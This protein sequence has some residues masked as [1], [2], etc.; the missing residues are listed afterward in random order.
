MNVIR[1]GRLLP[2]GVLVDEGQHRPMKGMALLPTE[3]QGHE[4]KIVFA[5]EITSRSVSVEI[6][7]AVLGRLLSLPIPEPVLL[8]DEHNKIFFGSV[9][10]D[11]PS[12]T[13]Y[14][15]NSSDQGVSNALAAWP[16]LNKA[17]YFDELIAMD[18]RHNGN[19]LY[20]GEDFILID[21]ESA[22]PSG[23]SP[24]MHGIEHYSNQLLQVATH[25]LDKNN[26]IAVQMMANEARSWSVTCKNESMPMLDSEIENVVTGKE[27][28]HLLSF[29]S[30]RIDLLGDILYEQIKPQQTQMIYDAKS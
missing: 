10:A 19:L 9:D 8:L 26:D 29:L 25:I 5:K 20:N 30:K 7:C 27:K 23:L 18:D 28:N 21:H 16:L 14:I 11:Y 2:G 1:V 17:S 3:S 12:F 13:Q 22:I 15:E 4:E 24:T 6:T